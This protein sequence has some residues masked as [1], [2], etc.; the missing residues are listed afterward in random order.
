MINSPKVTQRII[1]IRK[2]LRETM[3]YDINN[4]IND[5]NNRA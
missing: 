1:C 4:S 3:V 5:S 2:I